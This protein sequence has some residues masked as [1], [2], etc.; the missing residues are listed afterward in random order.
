MAD[1]NLDSVLEYAQI[2]LFAVSNFEEV[3]SAARK[4]AVETLKQKVQAN[5]QMVQMLVGEF[6]LVRLPRGQT[7]QD[8]KN[9]WQHWF[10]VA[11]DDRK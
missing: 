3:E 7:A 9:F 8:F 5:L 2:I 10:Y 1:T 4:H 6:G 11:R